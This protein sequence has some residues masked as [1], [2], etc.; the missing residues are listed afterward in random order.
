M[1]SA[2]ET[3][4]STPARTCSIFAR[5]SERFWRADSVS[6][7]ERRAERATMR[8]FFVVASWAFWV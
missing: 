1:I 7:R 2:S 3:A 5:A 4:C 6:L 8:F